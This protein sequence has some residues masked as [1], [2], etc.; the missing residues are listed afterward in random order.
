MGSVEVQRLLF[1]VGLASEVAVTVT[2]AILFQLL[3]RHAIRHRYFVIWS[4]A[5]AVLAASLAVLVPYMRAA[6]TFA[7]RSAMPASVFLSYA[8]Y[9]T[10]KLVYLLLLVVGTMRF[11]GSAR[12]RSLLRVGLA[13]A[14]GYAGL[15][16]LLAPDFDETLLMQ[17]PAVVGV[18]A[19]CAARLLRLPRPRRTLGT[20]LTGAAFAA[21]AAVWALNTAPFLQFSR[22]FRITIGG[23]VDWYGQYGSY[24][25]LL[26][27]V[28]L[29]LGMVVLLFEDLRRETLSAYEELSLSH[30]H[31]E[32]EAFI[33]ALTGTYNRS[34]F[35]QGHGTALARATFGAVALFDLD[36]FKPINDQH[37]HVVGDRLLVHFAESLRS[38]LRPTDALFRW[39][40]DEFLAILPSTT[41]AECQPHLAD[42]VSAVPPFPLDTGLPAVSVRAS[43]GSADYSSAEDLDAAIALADR[44]M[45]EAKRRR[46]TDAGRPQ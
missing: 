10:G 25:D 5:W 45:Y 35:A 42:A 41:A 19:F 14:L 16:V 6:D 3:R 7:D 21:K 12:W 9:H 2:I 39:G 34:A 18:S 37:G 33:D 24:V 11:V 17:V 20:R 31:L 43:V 26:V 1:V 36:D 32:R 30:R 4:W 38:Q 40:G 23:W 28:C 46:K 44:R 29:G 15:S 13:V 8:L 22:T 27:A